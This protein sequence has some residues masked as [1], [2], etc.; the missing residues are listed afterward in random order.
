MYNFFCD[1]Y[2]LIPYIMLI[3]IQLWPVRDTPGAAAG[4]LQEE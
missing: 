2:Y 4:I 1:A 3:I